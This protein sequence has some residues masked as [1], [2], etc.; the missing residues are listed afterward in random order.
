VPK[1]GVRLRDFASIVAF[2]SDQEI[3]AMQVAVDKRREARACLA[4]AETAVWGAELH[5]TETYY[6]R[7]EC[8]E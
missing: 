7:E 6:S 2:L 1:G 8:V 4:D 5:T 3:D